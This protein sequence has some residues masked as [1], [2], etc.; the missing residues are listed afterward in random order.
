MRHIVKEIS[1]EMLVSRLPSVMPA[2]MDGILYFF[3][4]NS[5]NGRDMLYPTNYGMSPLNIVLNVDPKDGHDSDEYELVDFTSEDSSHCHCYGESPYDELPN[6]TLSFKELSNWYYFFIEYYKLLKEYGHCGR[7]YT[8]AIDYYNNESGSKYASQMKYGNDMQT[9]I[10]LDNEFAAKGGKVVKSDISDNGF[11]K[12]ICDNI[13]PSF[14]IPNE[15]K[16][17]W[18]KS[19]LYY[20]EVLKWISWFNTRKPL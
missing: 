4:E 1:M 19:V 20:P 2:F 6:F 13:V 15:Y 3:D 9:Y 7:M 16:D 18:N 11:F 5:I 14:T 12:W 10:D 17:Y 8:S